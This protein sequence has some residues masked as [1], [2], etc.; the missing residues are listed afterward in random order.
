MVFG[1][2]PY[3]RTVN[4]NTNDAA[5]RDLKNEIRELAN[6]LKNVRT[7]YD[8]TVMRRAS[9][10]LALNHAINLL[11]KLKSNHYIKLR[12]KLEISR[13]LEEINTCLNTS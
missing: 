10:E 3:D 9:T 6:E 5:I 1:A 7:T 8:L 4:I 12:E 13:V 2:N 11:E